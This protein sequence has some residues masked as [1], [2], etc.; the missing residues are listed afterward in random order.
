V[1]SSLR[2][3]LPSCIRVLMT[4]RTEFPIV[5]EAINRGEVLRVIQKPFEAS[6][7]RRLIREAFGVIERWRVVHDAQKKAVKAAEQVMLEECLLND[8][9]Q[10]A[11]QP[12]VRAESDRVFGY[13]ALL[14]STH[15]V[16]EGP[17]SILKVAE[18][19]GLLDQL[20]Y[21]VA[22]RAADVLA[23]IPPD[24][25]LFINLHPEQLADPALISHTLSPLVPYARRCVLEI[26]ER[27]R[28][29]AITNWEE[30][31]DRLQAV[32]FDIAVDDLGAGYNALSI[33]ADLQPR[34]IKIDMS[35]IRNLDREPR[36]VRLVDLLCRFGEAT[37]SLVIAEGV[38]TPAEAETLRGCGTH[39]LQGYY[40]GRPDVD[41]EKVVRDYR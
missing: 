31:V 22:C 17:V 6:R 3:V 13:E 30:T 11:I 21:L 35:I 15:P 18:R 27:S 23:R 7:I 14:R 5:V 8:D 37:N 38:E 1:L 29:R 28:L 39:L 41:I 4:G 26:T 16:L 12:I 40:F 33:L 20:G 19:S 25:V 36:R 2:D 9:F 32:G 34:Y 24:A 10:L